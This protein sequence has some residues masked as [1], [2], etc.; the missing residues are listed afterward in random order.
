MKLSAHWLAVLGLQLYT[1]RCS[2]AEPIP[3]PSGQYNVGVQKHVI[4]FV[5]Q[6]DPTSPNSVSTEYLA[7]IYYPTRDEPS[8][9]KPYLEPE[10]AQAYADVWDFDIAHL[11]STFRE[12]AS[13]LCK[14][15]GP[16][17]LFGPG[18]WGPPTDGYGILFSELVSHGYV[19]A[20]LDH[21]YEQPFLR[22]P[23][24]TGVYG[25]ALD[26]PAEL[27]FI[28]ALHDVRV[29]ESLHFIDY[30]PDLVAEIGAPFKTDNLGAFG[31]S[32]GGS[33][34]LTLAL[35]SDKIV[36]AINQ[37]GSHLNRLNS[38]ADQAD[39]G[40]TPSLILG[41]E[42]HTGETDGTW[43]NFFKWQTGWWRL[44][45]VTGSSH[46]EF[47]DAAFWKLFGEPTRPLGPIEGQRMVDVTNAYI[48]AFF[49]E[50][51]LGQDQPILDGP[52]EEWPEVVYGGGNGE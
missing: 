30:L 5:N 14:P 7:T 35:E 44:F 20:A 38:T 3:L 48:K 34:A 47:S 4:E 16:T 25:L 31:H 17:L 8:E 33:T 1:S 46:L 52:S 12:N 24:G 22:Y 26:F 39:L 23:N 42:G 9:P 37:D 19:V 27:P 40:S 45:I 15:A 10:L 6:D 11:T 51:L 2:L 50:Y 49:D 29:R 36:A 43:A 32:L 41:S 21:L 13:F 18:G 28:E